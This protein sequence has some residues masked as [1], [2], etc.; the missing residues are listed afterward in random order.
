MFWEWRLKHGPPARS[1][2]CRA[3]PVV[4]A[5]TSRQRWQPRLSVRASAAV[6]TSVD[7][8]CRLVASSTARSRPRSGGWGLVQQAQQR[9]Q[10]GAVAEHTGLPGHGGRQGLAGAAG[11]ISGGGRP[12]QACAVPDPASRPGGRLVGDGGPAGHRPGGR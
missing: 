9:L 11:L 1:T 12:A 5:G 4:T 10:P 7:T 8:V 6:T 2:V 3:G